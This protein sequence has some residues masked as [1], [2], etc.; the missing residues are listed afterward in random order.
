MSLVG[1]V[2]VGE[3]EAL[4]AEAPALRTNRQ[5]R[6]IPSPQAEVSWENRYVRRPRHQRPTPTPATAAANNTLIDAANVSE[7]CRKSTP[8][9]GTGWESNPHDPFGSQD[10]KSCASASFATPAPRR[11][12]G[13]PQYSFAN[14]FHSERLGTVL[15]LLFF[16]E[17]RG[18]V[19]PLAFVLCLPAALVLAAAPDASARATVTA[20]A[21]ERRAFRVRLAAGRRRPWASLRNLLVARDRGRDLSDR[22]GQRD[23][24]NGAD[25]GPH[26]V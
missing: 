17:L 13:V 11:S 24:R 3:A 4:K 23:A 7:R 20:Q 10:F 9:T 25:R 15:M 5:A 12:G 2:R 8:M 16:R 1:A 14:S 21:P 18:V 6:R 26:R 22:S 19:C